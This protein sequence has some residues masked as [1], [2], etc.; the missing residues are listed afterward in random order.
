M[1]GVY[2]LISNLITEQEETPSVQEFFMSVQP[3]VIF[4]EVVGGS[5]SWAF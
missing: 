3:D 4:D 2:L 1:V 5:D